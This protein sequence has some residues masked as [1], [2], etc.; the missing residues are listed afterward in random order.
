MNI[1]SISPL[2]S[3]A[4]ELDESLSGVHLPEDFDDV[5][6]ACGVSEDALAEV[7]ARSVRIIGHRRRDAAQTFLFGDDLVYVEGQMRDETVFTE[8]ATGTFGYDVKYLSKFMRISTELAPVRHRCISMSMSSTQ[9]IEMLPRTPRERD[10]ILVRLE[11]G[12]KVT[13]ARI[14]NWGKEEE[15]PADPFALSGRKGLMGIGQSNLKSGV[16]TFMMLVGRL[17]ARI[18]AELEPGEGRK[19]RA[20]QKGKLNEDV[21]SD[22]REAR[23]HLKRIACGLQA[24]SVGDTSPVALPKGSAWRKVQD[25]VYLL[26][27]VEGAWPNRGEMRSWMTDQVVPTLRFALGDGEALGAQVLPDAP[28]DEAAVTESDAARAEAVAAIVVPVV[29][30]DVAKTAS[31]LPQPKSGEE[32]ARAVKPRKPSRGKQIT[33]QEGVAMM[34]EAAGIVSPRP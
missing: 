20:I 5:A 1:T 19:P 8:F 7:R 15:A 13:A 4:A 12:E 14:K 34:V 31:Q 11:D 33:A 28:V 17:L 3:S 32:K 10:E 16:S 6:L 9:L 2:M 22:A 25:L 24:D 29:E 23:G 21:R 27:C 18:E 30:A 26:G